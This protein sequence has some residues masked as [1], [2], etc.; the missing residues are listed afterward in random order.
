MLGTWEGCHGK[1]VIDFFWADYSLATCKES[2]GSVLS[3]YTTL[4]QDDKILCGLEMRNNIGHNKVKV[5]K[6]C[7]N[8]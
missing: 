8:H 6:R 3:I 2:A 5:E 1:N 7:S 4:T